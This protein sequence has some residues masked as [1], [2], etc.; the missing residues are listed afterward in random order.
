LLP[1]LILKIFPKT[2]FKDSKAETVV[3]E[4]AYGKPPVLLKN[5]SEGSLWQLYIGAF[6]SASN[7][8]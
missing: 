8:R 3:P 6:F 1:L 4:N 5:S 2:L 7:E